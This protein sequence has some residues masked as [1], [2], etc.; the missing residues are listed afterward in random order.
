MGFRNPPQ[1]HIRK[2]HGLVGLILFA[3]PGR[4]E[5]LPLRRVERTCGSSKNLPDRRLTGLSDFVILEISL[6]MSGNGTTAMEAPPCEPSQV[7]GLRLRPAFPSSGDRT[8]AT[9]STT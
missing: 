9:S 8:L 5:G 3:K 1:T 6:L 2:R 7:R 4:R